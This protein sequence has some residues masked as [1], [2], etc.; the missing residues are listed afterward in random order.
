MAHVTAQCRQVPPFKWLTSNCNLT[1]SICYK[2]LLSSSFQ[3]SQL[4]ESLKT[5]LSY[6]YIFICRPYQTHLVKRSHYIVWILSSLVVMGLVS[7]SPFF[8]GQLAVNIIVN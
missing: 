8:K 1:Y 5:F 4:F 3:K 7:I 6:R 2:L